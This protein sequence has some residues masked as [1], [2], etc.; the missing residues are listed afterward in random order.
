MYGAEE[1]LQ[2]A[3]QAMASSGSAVDKIL[4]FEMGRRDGAPVSLAAVIFR[5]GSINGSDAEMSEQ[6]EALSASPSGGKTAA[7]DDAPSDSGDAA[8]GLFYDL[9]TLEPAAPSDTP[10]VVTKPAVSQGTVIA[11][12]NK[13]DY[14]V[15]TS[16]LLKEALNIKLTGDAPSVLIIHTHSSEAYL[17]DGD[18]QYVASDFFRTQDKNESIIR[19]GDE[20]AEALTKNGITNVHDRNVYDYP[21][22]EGAYNR[23]YDAIQSYLKKYPSIQLVLDV[24]RDAIH[25]ADGTVYKTIAQIGDETCSQIMM[26]VGTNAS[27]ARTSS[28]RFICRTR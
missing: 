1:A 6:T 11:I 12:N 23:S 21:S 24:H 14:A 5:G 17:P 22:Y 28:W 8:G 20:L 7:S 3:L 4:S 18:D 26:V 19:V 15:N 27:G 2:S 16:V 9:G 10:N 13:T 25:G